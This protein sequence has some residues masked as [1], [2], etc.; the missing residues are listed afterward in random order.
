LGGSEPAADQALVDAFTAEGNALYP[1]TKFE[2]TISPTPLE[3]GIAM[4]ADYSQGWS[5]TLDALGA[6]LIADNPP[7]DM[8]YFG[9]LRPSASPLGGVTGLA[10]GSGR[11]GSAGIGLSYPGQ[12]ASA[13][14]TFVHELGHMHSLKHSPGC[15]ADNPNPSYPN[16]D[17]KLDA[18][19]WDS[20]SNVLVDPT[21]TFDLMTYCSPIWTSAFVYKSLAKFVMQIASR[22]QYAT[23]RP[24]VR[25]DTVIVDEHGAPSWG[26]HYV[27]EHLPD[28][29]PE[30]VQALD[31]SGQLVATVTGYRLL[32]ADAGAALLRVPNIEPTWA[33][34]RIAGTATHLSTS[35]RPER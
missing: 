32:L 21:K 24:P 2:I 10:G 15:N 25:Y 5:E 35:T 31:A 9:L 26:T 16:P 8:H 19:G 20:R 34:L 13:V 29:D 14:E 22:S 17:G 3:T 1:S 33:T 12:T 7:F 28:G 18:W 30:P 6:R 23:P 11:V 4:G 27:S